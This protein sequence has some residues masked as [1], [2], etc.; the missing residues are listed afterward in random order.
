VR[1]KYRG[2][3]LVS[4][5][6]DRPPIWLYALGIATF[7]YDSK[8]QMPGVRLACARRSDPQ[9]DVGV[10]ES[11]ALNQRHY[12]RQRAA[13]ESRVGAMGVRRDR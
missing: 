2:R 6:R 11:S 13:P 8:D 1:T 7:G 9:G 10:G 4:D 5:L 3:H 12:G